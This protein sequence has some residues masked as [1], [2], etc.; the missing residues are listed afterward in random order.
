VPA[1]LEGLE[2]FTLAES[3]GGVESLIAHPTSMTHA[4]MDETARL[5]AGIGP[6]LL[7]VSVGIE[8]SDDLVADLKAGL[9]RALIKR[10]APHLP[11]PASTP[12]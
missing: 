1:F 8:D 10:P 7:R 12:A 3:L 2:C 9:E 6:G 5:R 11:R 4:G